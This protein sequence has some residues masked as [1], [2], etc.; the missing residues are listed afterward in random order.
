MDLQMRMQALALQIVYLHMPTC[1]AS[2]TSIGGVSVWFTKWPTFPSPDV[3]VSHSLDAI[4]KRVYS[5]A[6]ASTTWP[7]P[8]LQREDALQAWHVL[9]A[10]QCL[11]PA[12][13]DSLKLAE[14]SPT[15]QMLVITYV[16]TQRK[17]SPSATVR[18]ACAAATD[19]A[20]L[21]RNRNIAYSYFQNPFVPE[22]VKASL[23]AHLDRLI[24]AAAT[25]GDGGDA[26]LRAAFADICRKTLEIDARDDDTLRRILK[27]HTGA[28]A[29]GAPATPTQAPASAV[30]L[31]PNRVAES[32]SS[33]TGS[34]VDAAVAS[35]ITKDKASPGLVMT[36]FV[37]ARPI[38]SPQ[39]AGTNVCEN[40]APSGMAPLD[41]RLSAPGH[42]R[43][44]EEADEKM[45]VDFPTNGRPDGTNGDAEVAGVQPAGELADGPPPG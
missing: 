25:A 32:T 44:E 37:P 41:A 31:Q 34:P 14:Y 8:S 23:F 35:S 40:G 17:P 42:Q 10:F 1:L 38:S 12:D 5:F 4:L 27:L 21:I 16:V 18:R 22:S 7:L 43:V 24:A 30:A 28:K 20:V 13:I 26:D 15:N 39:D 29:K 9:A 45:K 6:R 36:S 11:S 2:D 33:R 3:I 19:F